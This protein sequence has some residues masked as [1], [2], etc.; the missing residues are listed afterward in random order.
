MSTTAK[1]VRDIET[2]ASETTLNPE[3]GECTVRIE[4]TRKVLLSLTGAELM[5]A[6]YGYSRPRQLLPDTLALRFRDGRL[7]EITVV[8]GRLTKG[9]KPGKLRDDV[10]FNPDGTRRYY[11]DVRDPAPEDIMAIVRRYA[12]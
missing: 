8:G 3:T 2:R 4:T 11:S 6:G 1:L 9:G 10:A 7:I 5:T 12:A